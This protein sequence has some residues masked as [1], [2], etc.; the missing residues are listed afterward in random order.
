M[1]MYAGGILK[2]KI[3]NQ[4]LTLFENNSF[5]SIFKSNGNALISV[6]V[7]MGL[8]SILAI[9]LGSMMANLNRES[10]RLTQKMGVLQMQSEILNIFMNKDKCLFNLAAGPFNL[11]NMPSTPNSALPAYSKSR[12]TLQ[13]IRDGQDVAAPAILAS[14][15]QIVN[16]MGVTISSIDLKNWYTSGANSYR[17]DLVINITSDA[18]PLA[19][20]QIRN[21][22]IITTGPSTAANI[23]FCGAPGRGQPSPGPAIATSAWNIPL[24]VAGAAMPTITI[25]LPS[26]ANNVSVSE[27]C[28]IS[29]P[30]GESTL[31]VHLK[32][33][34]NDIV[35]T[36]TVCSI[37]G[38][39]ESQTGS[40]GNS[41]SFPVPAGVVSLVIVGTL[42]TDGL[43]TGSNGS[44]SVSYSGQIFIDELL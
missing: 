40:T 24:F 32:D 16:V 29:T 9:A 18:G 42:T 34:A 7:S 37:N 4:Y 10:R 14:G 22:R 8:I 39:S 43:W 31:Q 3:K 41:V 23:V 12:K 44:N 19:P 21:L 15:E 11:A 28:R 30:N 35:Q 13:M 25:Q 38:V 17:A 36:L 20:I 33:A 6:L 2:S 27:D 5:E 26:N 1:F